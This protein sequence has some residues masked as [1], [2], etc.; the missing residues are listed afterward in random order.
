MPASYGFARK[1]R[2][3]MW[4]LERQERR[5]PVLK[6]LFFEKVRVV[7]DENLRDNTQ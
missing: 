1:W 6:R 7:E 3:V 4:A 2:F 5:L